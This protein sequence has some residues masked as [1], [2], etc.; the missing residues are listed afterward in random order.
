MSAP[1]LDRRWR[2]AGEWHRQ[3]AGPQSPACHPARNLTSVQL[4]WCEPSGERKRA[5][6][7]RQEEK[8][9]CYVV[10]R[11]NADIA[12]GVA[13]AVD[14]VPSTI[15]TACSRP[16]STSGTAPELTRTPSTSAEATP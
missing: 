3:R 10:G 4:S 12:I 14:G 7:R 6:R 1:H 15:V 5:F 16:S 11:V 2:R 9:D 13:A 8:R